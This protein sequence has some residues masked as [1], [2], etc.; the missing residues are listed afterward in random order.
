MKEISKDY[1]V[2]EWEIPQTDGGSP[3]TGY[4]IE[5][6]DM[7]RSSYVKVSEVSS[8]CLVLKADKL[9]EDNEYLFRVCAENENGASEWTTTAEPIKAKYPFGE[10]S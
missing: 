3:I 9:V 4:V 5:K 6:R 1:A 8:D 10:S 2:L 7:K